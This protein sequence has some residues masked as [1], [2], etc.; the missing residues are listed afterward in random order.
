MDIFKILIS[1]AIGYAF[2]CLQTAYILG[3]I[4]K[5]ID[6]RKHGTNNSGASNI[7]QVLGWKYGIFTA[8]IDILKA[9]AA[10]MIVKTI[11]PGVFFYQFI[12]G[13]FVLLGHIFPAYMRF[14]GGKGTASLI[15]MMI[16]IDI[17]IAVILAVTIVVITLITDYIAIGSMAMFSL[18]PVSSYLFG[19][20]I[21]SILIG[22]ILCIMCI[23]LHRINIKRIIAHEEVGLR[24]V[25]KKR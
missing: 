8:I 6:I 9:T 19:Y 24:A 12:A 25:A 18:L 20:D 2:G 10:V 5:K 1:A 3:R 16:G 22:I 21:Y 13:S 7:T 23:L 14:K 11:Y 4:V 15:G 17:R